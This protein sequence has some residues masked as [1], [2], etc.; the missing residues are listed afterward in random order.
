M[1][2]YI[3]LILIIGIFVGFYVQTVIGFAG[4]LMALPILLFGMELPDAIAY[5]SIFYLFSSAFLIA[6]EWKN[7]NRKIILRLALASVIGV[8]LGII[9]LTFTKPILLKK[10]LGIFILL[11]VG[12]VFLGKK[13]IKLNKVGIISFGVMA[14]FFS[15]IFSTGGPLYVIC[16]ENS[17]KEMKTFRAT[18]IGVLGLVTI[19][20]VPTLA[21]SG[22]LDFQHI[23]MSLLVF[24]V[25]LFAQFLGKQT[26]EKINENL[27]K[28]LLIGLLCISSLVLVF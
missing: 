22:I 24:P 19:A 1:D 3:F 2:I 17:V 12:Y 14:G 9:V 21:I 10:G 15:G 7:I 6:K 4:S 28:K 20:R 27:F 23:K 25:F 26:F 8:I 18:M 11:Y 16:I 5:I 13:K